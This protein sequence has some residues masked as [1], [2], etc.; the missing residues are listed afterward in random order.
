MM[1]ITL[2]I[3]YCHSQ[4]IENQKK[5]KI[6]DICDIC[7]HCRLIVSILLIRQQHIKFYTL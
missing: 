2:T 5:T 4:K 1:A 3:D 6:I 7:H